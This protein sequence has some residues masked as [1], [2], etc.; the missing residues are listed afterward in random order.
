MTIAIAVNLSILNFRPDV[1]ITIASSSQLIDIWSDVL[2]VG[3][4]QVWLSGSG[5]KRHLMLYQQGTQLDHFEA[6]WVE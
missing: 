4:D 6:G 3:S 1:A 2:L 5:C